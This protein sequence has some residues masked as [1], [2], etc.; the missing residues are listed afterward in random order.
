[1]KFLLIAILAVALT[2]ATG[3]QMKTT[4][5]GTCSCIMPESIS[6]G[7]ENDD[8]PVYKAETLETRNVGDPN[9]TYTIMK[10]MTV[11]RGCAPQNKKIIVKT[12]S[13]KNGCGVDFKLRETYVVTAKLSRTS[14]PPPGLPVDMETYMATSCDYNKKWDACPYK[15]KL[16]LYYTPPHGC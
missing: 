8:T 9:Y 14:S 13:S 11:F 10:V 16:F 1:M 3:V 6:E 4:G 5:P 2:I 15:E 7:Y 12:P